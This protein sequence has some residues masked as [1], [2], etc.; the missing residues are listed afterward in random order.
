[1]RKE[2]QHWIQHE[3]TLSPA[4]IGSKCVSVLKSESNFICDLKSEGPAVLSSEKAAFISNIQDEKSVIV[5]FT[6]ILNE[7]LSYLSPDI[8]L[9]NCEEYKW[10]VQSPG[11]LKARKLKPDLFV[12]Y[13]GVFD[14]RNEPND[15]IKDLRKKLHEENQ[16]KFYFG[17][18]SIFDSIVIM[19]A[20]VQINKYEDFGKV[21][22]F[23]FYF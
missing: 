3:N 11:L 9:V 13:H 17:I 15:K 23:L 5:H 4:E 12:T 18:P 8:I 19:E 21:S 1:V 2:I 16:Q 20:K 22:L 10:L 7:V 6:C 14:L